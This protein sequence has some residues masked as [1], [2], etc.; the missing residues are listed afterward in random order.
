MKS[1]INKENTSAVF[2]K[3]L[4]LTKTQDFWPLLWLKGFILVS[5]LYNMIPHKSFFFF[6]KKGFYFGKRKLFLR[7]ESH[8]L[9]KV[10]N[11]TKEVREPMTFLLSPESYASYFLRL[12]KNT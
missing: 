8:D 12:R 10:H 2:F 6:F 3:L 9:G 1:N 5:I 11:S 7:Y 4:H